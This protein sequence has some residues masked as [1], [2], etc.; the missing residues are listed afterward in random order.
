MDLDL[1]PTQEALRQS[2]E[3]FARE[4]VEPW[5]AVIDE[6]G[7]FPTDLIREAGAL[8][9]MGLTVPEDWGGGGHDYVGYALALEAIARASATVAVILSVNNSLVAETIARFGSPAQKKR[10]LR[11]LATGTA[12]GAFALSEEHAGTDA[13]NQQTRATPVAGSAERYMVTGKK[14]WV[15][16]AEAADAAIVFAALAPPSESSALPPPSATSSWLPPSPF[17][18]SASSGSSRAQSRD[19]AAQGAPSMSRGAGGRQPDGARYLQAGLLIL[20][21]LFDPSGPYLSTSPSHQ[22]LLLHSIYHRPGGW[23]HVPSGART[24]RGE[25]SQWG[26]Y[27]AREAALY[28]Q[29]L[30]CDGPYLMFCGDRARATT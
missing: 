8:G 21:T 30:A 20:D 1:T 6:G 27:H 19:D 28:V 24:P 23:D 15:A 11:A 16:N 29:R 18:P 14:V 9:L 17:D 2:A 5:S 7:E 12:V 25:S 13:Q 10:W 26:D 3:R 22:G 4:R